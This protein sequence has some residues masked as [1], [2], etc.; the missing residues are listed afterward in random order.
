MK[1]ALGENPKKAYEATRMGIAAT[2][3]NFLFQARAYA[4]DPNRKFDMKLEPMIPV[5]RGEKALEAVTINPARVMGVEARV[6]SL[7]PGKDAD[8]VIWKDRPF[9]VIQD[10]VAVFINGERI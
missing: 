3:R 8:L 1:C 10:P 6:G 5:I 4:Q 7:A 2:L 9:V